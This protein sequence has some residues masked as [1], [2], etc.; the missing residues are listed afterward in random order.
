VSLQVRREGATPNLLKYSITADRDGGKI[1]ISREELLRDAIN[2]PLR[3]Y[4]ARAAKLQ[5]DEDACRYLMCN[6]SMRVFMTGQ[7]LER[8]AVDA[9]VGDGV[10]SL[11]IAAEPGAKAI[12]ALEFRHSVSA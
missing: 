3:A 7:T 2:G 8:V 5:T 6:A 9:R 4:I 1:V 10:P 12:L 11:H